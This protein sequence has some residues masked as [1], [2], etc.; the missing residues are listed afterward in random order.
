[1]YQTT[2]N[3]REQELIENYNQQG[4]NENYPQFET[5]F[6]GN[7]SNNYGFGVSN[8]C[9]PPNSSFIIAAALRDVPY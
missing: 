2:R 1:M 5:N 8:I 4:I 3:E 6:W 9:T 7:S